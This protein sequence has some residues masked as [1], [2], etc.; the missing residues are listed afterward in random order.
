MHEHLR[1]QSRGSRLHCF[2]LYGLGGVG[3]S[4]TAAA[5]AYKY[6][7][8]K[9]HTSD[10]DTVFWIDSESEDAMR[11]SFREVAQ[12]LKGPAIT[13][14]TDPQQIRREVQNWL[15]E[16][17]A[18]GITNDS[19]HGSAVYEVFETD[20]EWL[21]IYDNANSWNTIMGYW[22]QGP[23]TGAI[24]ITSRDFSL[25]NRPASAGEELSTLGT[26]ESS[27]LFMCLLDSYDENDE[28]EAKAFSELLVYLDGLP[29]AI[30][31]IASFINS[32]RYTVSEFFQHYKRHRCQIH[33]ERG[34]NSYAFYTHSLQSVWRFAFQNIALEQETMVLLGIISFLSPDGIPKNLFSAPHLA[35]SLDYLAF[36][37]DEFMSV[38]VISLKGC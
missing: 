11:Q 33:Q 25:A 22:P 31:Q 18:Y 26:K 2:T 29:L 6:A 36:C 3:K 24:I 30:Q 1:P 10:Y 34:Y 38:I 21:I 32:R 4:Q 8:R 27:N 15:T 14:A 9:G 37:K 5:Y 7:G 19:A 23:S 12:A 16:T 17:G 35:G 20:R 13:A 28:E